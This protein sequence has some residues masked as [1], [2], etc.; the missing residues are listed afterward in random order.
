MLL[1]YYTDY[2][3]LWTHLLFEM[4]WL[5]LCGWIN[6]I[7]YF[8]SLEK[9]NHI[10]MWQIKIEALKVPLQITLCFLFQN[11][12]QLILL[13]ASE[14]RCNYAIINAFTNTSNKLGTFFLSNSSYIGSC[15]CILIQQLLAWILS[16][17]KQSCSWKLDF[18]TNV[19]KL[20]IKCAEM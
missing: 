10:I 3:V 6:Q 1:K 13:Q 18:F 4:C 8:Q 15:W 19:I 14:G 5:A 7:H 2:T 12:K 20:L 17:F 9:I 11:I 16:I